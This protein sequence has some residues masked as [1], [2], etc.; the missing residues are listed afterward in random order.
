MYE[1][2]EL[3]KM[4]ATFTD[5]CDEFFGSTAVPEHFEEKRKEI[6]S[7]VNLHQQSQEQVVLV[8]V[9]ISIRFSLMFSLAKRKHL[10]ESL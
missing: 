1:V 3:Y 7:F 8:T 9:S 4:S 6:Q 5:S 2:K 10:S